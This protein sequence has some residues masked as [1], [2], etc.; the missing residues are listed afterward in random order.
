MN[1][2]PSG[3]TRTKKPLGAFSFI[4]SILAIIL[5]LCGQLLAARRLATD[6][7]S[8]HPSMDQTIVHLLL[9]APTIIAAIVAVW[10]GVS[11]FRNNHRYRTLAL[12]GIGL[13]ILSATLTLLGFPGDMAA[14]YWIEPRPEDH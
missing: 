1:T 10:L 11:S 6:W 2:P 13:G 3:L 5:S 14:E 12:F 7:N 4:A 8:G 9:V